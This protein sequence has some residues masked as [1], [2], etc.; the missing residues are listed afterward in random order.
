MLEILV[1]MVTLFLALANK[2]KR[3]R[4]ISLLKGTFDE[5]QAMGALAN[6]TGILAVLTDSVDVESFLLSVEATYALRDHTPAEGPIEIYAAHSDYTL[7]EVEEFIENTQ[8]W[9]RGDLRQQEIGRRKIRRVGV[10]SGLDTDEVL[11]DG[12]P[13]KTALK[14][15]CVQGAGMNYCIYNNSGAALTTGTTFE[16]QGHVWIK[17]T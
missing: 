16:A 17:A 9:S 12:K 2:P 4:R 7:V 13:L 6:A 11:N 8:S 3:R 10:F 14:W 5:T 15:S 1:L